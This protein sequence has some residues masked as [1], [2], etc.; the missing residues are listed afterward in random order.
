MGTAGLPGSDAVVVL[1]PA[2]AKGL[3]FDAV[4][5]VEPAEVAALDNGLR[6][7][8]VAMTRAVQHLGIV[9]AQPLPPALRSPGWAL[10]DG[11]EQQDGG[12]R[13]HVHRVGP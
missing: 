1:G 2:T 6:H 4:V 10:A 5:V 7:L 12:R 11:F 13:A 8:Y 9:H 3:E